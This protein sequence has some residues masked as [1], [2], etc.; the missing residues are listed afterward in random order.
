MDRAKIRARYKKLQRIVW[1]I[2]TN[3]LK[4][5]LVQVFLKYM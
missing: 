1:K 4:N 5:M 2:I 3:L